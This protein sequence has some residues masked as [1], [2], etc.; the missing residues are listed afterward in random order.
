MKP[1]KRIPLGSEIKV[2]FTAREKELVLNHT[3]AGPDERKPLV[4]ARERHGVFVVSYGL[5]DLDELL[6]FIA[7][8]AN[9]AKSKKVQ[10]ELYGL[11]DKLQHV[12]EGYEDGGEA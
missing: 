9:H 3:L 5:D 2:L 11:Y 12:M 6:G 4:R 10:K 7:A 8:E 1:R